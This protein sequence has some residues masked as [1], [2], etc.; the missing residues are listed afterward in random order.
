VR[1]APDAVLARVFGIFESLIAFGVGLGSILAPALLAL[2]GVR[3]ALVATGVTLPLLAAVTWRRLT[4]LDHRL[5]ARDAEIGVLQGVGMLR[6]LPVPSIEHLARQLRRSTV[7]AGAAVIRQGD[8]G[9]AFY[10][11]V[12]GQ[13]EVLDAGAVVRSIGAGDSFGEIALL[14]DVPRTATVRARSDLT[15]FE[16]GRDP[17][18]EAV[19]GFRAS[20]D[21]A[22]DVVAGHLADHRPA[23]AGT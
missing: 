4:A 18:L 16:L 8:P 3:G 9:D 10:V 15:L 2:L 19:T 14:H 12:D 13:A 1:F 6:P 21:A 5:G 23:G 22:R 17:F 7:P 11:I 20:S